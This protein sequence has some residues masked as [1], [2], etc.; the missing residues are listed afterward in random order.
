MIKLAFDKSIHNRLLSDKS[1]GKY[2]LNLQEGVRA[3][4][5]E[6]GVAYEN[7]AM[8]DMCS[9]CNP[10]ILFSHRASQGKRGN[11]AAVMMLV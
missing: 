9:C 1:N 6:A 10:D 4:L 2:Q 11:L 7:I 3:T 5:V 8:P